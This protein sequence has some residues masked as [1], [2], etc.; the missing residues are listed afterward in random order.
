MSNF[1]FS[2]EL[3]PLLHLRYVK[4]FGCKLSCE[5]FFTYNYLKEVRDGVPH[6]NVLSLFGLI[7]HMRQK[8]KV[9]TNF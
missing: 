5:S 7:F 9:S 8:I 1:F 4:E 2:E 3:F 6:I